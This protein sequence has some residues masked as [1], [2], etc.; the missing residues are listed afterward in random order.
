[1]DNQDHD[2][3][4]DFSNGLTA[5][6]TERLELLAEE[7]SEVIQIA[8]KILR[9][10][11]A[12][13]HPDRNEPFDPDNREMLATELGHVAAAVQLMTTAGDVLPMHI[14]RNRA[15]KLASVG[16]YLHHHPQGWWKKESPNA[17]GG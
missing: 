13:K 1:M 5:A 17:I 7:C 4:Y 15:H 14:E 16:K 3:A 9:H 8:M 12:S 11:Y 6:E 10:G 2:P